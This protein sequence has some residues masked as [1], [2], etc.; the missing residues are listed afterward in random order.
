VRGEEGVQLGKVKLRLRVRQE[1]GQRPSVHPPVSYHDHRPPSFSHV[2]V[3]HCIS[4]VLRK[5]KGEE[6]KERPPRSQARHHGGPVRGD[7]AATRLRFWRQ[8]WGPRRRLTPTR[9]EAPGW[10]RLAGPGRRLVCRLLRG[11]TARP[12]LHCSWRYGPTTVGS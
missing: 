6:A 11:A 5:E 9:S 1:P 2:A 3:R 4:L 12:G 8:G 7:K 10:L